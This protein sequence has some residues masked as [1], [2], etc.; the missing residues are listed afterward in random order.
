ME[1]PHKAI[2][3]NLDESRGKFIVL[4]NICIGF[5]WQ[6]F[7]SG[8]LSRVGSMRTQAARN[9][10]CLTESMPA[11]S[12]TDTL[13]AEVESISNGGASGTTGSRRGRNQCNSNYRQRDELEYLRTRKAP[14]LEES[15]WRTTP[16]GMNH[17]RTICE[18]FRWLI[19]PKAHLRLLHSYCFCQK[20][21]L[22]SFSSET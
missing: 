19:T 13:S 20:L 12:K 16:C 6:T 7:A 1:K 2:S 11:S 22:P 10:P 3:S 21:K 14:M 9:F 18:E 4:K 5:V 8:R 17:A 15:Y